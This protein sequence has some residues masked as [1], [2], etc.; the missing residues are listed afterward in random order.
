[1]AGPD[2]SFIQRFPCIMRVLIHISIYIITADTGM[3]QR[4]FY[5]LF[6][7]PLKLFITVTSSL[8]SS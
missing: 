3:D 5:L 1:M 6:N 4:Q 2:V 8:S 7:L